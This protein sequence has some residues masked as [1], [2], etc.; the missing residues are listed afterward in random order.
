MK[1]AK[2]KPAAKGVKKAPAP[3]ILP[4]RAKSTA[5]G[6]NDPLR[7][8][9]ENAKDYAVCMLDPSGRVASWNIGAERLTGY[10]QDE[11]FGKPFSCFYSAEEIQRRR[12]EF[13][14][15]TAG[16]HGR[17]EEQTWRVRKDGSR[18]FANVLITAMRRAK[19]TLTGFSLITRDLTDVRFAEIARGIYES[20]PD[21]IAVIDRHGRI[22]QMNAQV[23]SIFG[24]SR[25]ELQDKPVEFLMP[26][27]FR[28]RHVKHITGYIADPRMRPMGV[29]LELFGQRKDK[30]EFPVDIMLSPM[31]TESGSM[32]IAV[33]R[34]VTAPKQATESARKTNEELMALV[35]ELQ[36]RE[37]EMQAL[38]SMDDLLQSCTR[39]E[40]A[41]QGRWPGRWRAF[42]RADRMPGSFAC[43]GSIS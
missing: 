31:T 36:R 23:E 37:S 33:V 13:V 39:S 6:A 27:R 41:Y 2:K 42:C 32:V 28:E 17:Y 19:G 38:I 21:A 40:E 34:D 7:L 1:P 4:R 11:I 16:A 15:K 3:P 25:N 18:F 26:E 29:G 30:S 14:L 9:I 12:P 22:T 5:D 35:A 43:V 10:R 8:L 20:F 24:Y